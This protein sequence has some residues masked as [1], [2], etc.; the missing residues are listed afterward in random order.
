[1]IKIEIFHKKSDRIVESKEF[2][3]E[4]ALNRFKFYWITQCNNHIYGYRVVSR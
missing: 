2:E 1:M 4:R 3:S